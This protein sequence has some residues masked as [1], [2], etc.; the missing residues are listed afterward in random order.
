MKNYDTDN[1]N[2]YLDKEYKGLS[3]QSCGKTDKNSKQFLVV[4]N[5]DEIE[6]FGNVGEKILL[7]LKCCGSRE[8]KK[9]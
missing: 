6:F 9:V 1:L 7:C 5:V 8:G 2:K 4:D 3:C